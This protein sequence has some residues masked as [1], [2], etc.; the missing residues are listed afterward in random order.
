MKI[1]ANEKAAE[2]CTTSAR[3][4]LRSYILKFFHRVCG[5]WREYLWKMGR[6]KFFPQRL[7][8]T[9]KFHTAACG[10]KCV[11]PLSKIPLF[12]ITFPY[13]CHYYL[14]L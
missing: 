6:K 1:I 3:F 2:G 5:M 12:H 4:T 13:Y 14:N 7:L 11:E 10:E 8:K 9:G